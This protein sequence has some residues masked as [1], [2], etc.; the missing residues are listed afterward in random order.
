MSWNKIIGVVLTMCIAGP[1]FGQELAKKEIGVTA[2]AQTD[3]LDAIQSTSTRAGPMVFGLLLGRD[4]VEDVASR[5]QL[6]DDSFCK[7]IQSK[8]GCRKTYEITDLGWLKDKGNSVSISEYGE[9]RPVDAE[10]FFAKF[11]V[12]GEYL[13]GTFFKGTLA[14]ISITGRFEG[15]TLDSSVDSKA[16]IASFDKKYKKTVPTMKS[17]SEHGITDKYTYYA[18]KE[19]ANSFEVLL[20][21]HDSILVNKLA[22][23]QNL[24]R[25]QRVLSGVPSVY[26]SIKQKC[27]GSFV[28]HELTYREPKLY[29]QAFELS[30][31]LKANAEASKKKA[32]SHRVNKY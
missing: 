20:T 3:S 31:Q 9:L 14:A 11:S 32:A 13:T 4:N 26:A 28:E 22:C 2:G 19:S 12:D 5:V 6:Q 24:Q 1:S 25:L 17:T 23:L 18:W 8:E 21:R 29:M 30:R 7:I 16:L 10:V 27:G 15:D